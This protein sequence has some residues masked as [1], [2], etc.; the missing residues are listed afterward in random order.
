MKQSILVIDRSQD[1]HQLL[2]DSLSSLNVDLQHAA[3]GESGFQ[4]AC[5]NPPDLIL[6][7]VQMPDACGFEIC[8]WLKATPETVSVPIIFL[9]GESDVEQKV[10]GFDA[11]A[12]DCIQKPF[13]AAELMARVCAA[14]RTKRYLDLLS[15]RAMLDGLTGL[16]NRSQFDQRLQE[17]VACAIQSGSPLSL[18]MLDIDCFK[19]INDSFGHP[20][21]D[22]ILQSI[23][24]KILC[25]T[26]STDLACR[27]GGEE[28]GII[29]RKMEL[30]DAQRVAGQLR[31]AL[32]G[33]VF[34]YRE[35]RI[36]VTAS[37]GVS[38]MSLCRNV[39]EQSSNWLISSADRALYRAK[40]Q[41][42]NRVCSAGD[43]DSMQASQDNPD[44]SI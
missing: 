10:K 9:T 21:G 27:Y 8:S 24:E 42:R 20:F 44:T 25:S 33:L 32:E 22:R 29:L 43:E 4:K 31:T 16:C 38:A 23:G 41:G 35:T 34:Q 3:S 39:D 40:H 26:R 14:L 36:S 2:Y 7:D 6:L 12:V 1:I 11:G 5:Q 13:A 28:F 17:E 15:Q 30:C 37:F 18:I 19:S